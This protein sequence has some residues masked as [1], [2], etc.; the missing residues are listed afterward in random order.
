M[1]QA[2][3]VDAHIHTSVLRFD[4]REH[5]QNLLLVTQVTL[6]RHQNTTVTCT[7]TLSCQFLKSKQKRCQ[8]YHQ[9]SEAGLIFNTL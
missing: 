4:G 2:S 9:L 5:G 8:H 7:L 1:S 3:V 6:E